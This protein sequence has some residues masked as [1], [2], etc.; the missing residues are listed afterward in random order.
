[1]PY[2]HSSSNEFTLHDRYSGSLIA[3]NPQ[4]DKLITSLGTPINSYDGRLDKDQPSYYNLLDAFR[5][6][7]KG[8]RIVKK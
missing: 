4:F 7:L 6:A 2:V 5:L 3:I 8:I 1:M